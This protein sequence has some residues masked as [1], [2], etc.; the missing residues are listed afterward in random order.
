MEKMRF[1]EYAGGRGL[2]RG[3]MKMMDV[4]IYVI[5]KNEKWIMVYCGW[6]SF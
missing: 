1:S 6:R 5:G 3:Y 4:N 2:K